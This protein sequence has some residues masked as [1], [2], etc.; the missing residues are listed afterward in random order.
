MKCNGCGGE[1]TTLGG[2]FGYSN[3]RMPEPYDHPTIFAENIGTA[4]Y[5]KPLCPR[6][7]HVLKDILLSSDLSEQWENYEWGLIGN[8]HVEP[9]NDNDN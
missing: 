2:F 3:A 6:C 7:Q 8:E 9:Y 5:I 4:D 1:F